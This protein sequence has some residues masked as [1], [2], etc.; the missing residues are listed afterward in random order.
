MISLEKPRLDFLVH[1]GI[2]GMHWGVRN[3]KEK[4]RYRLKLE[5][6]YTKKGLDS[7]EA[8][9][10]ASKRIKIEKILAVTAGIT[11]VAATAYVLHHNKEVKKAADE[12]VSKGTIFN[13]IAQSPDGNI[14]KKTFVS[15]LPE[16][17]R[18]Y[19]NNLTFANDFENKSMTYQV[20]LKGIHNIV[21]PSMKT[22][23]KLLLDVVKQNSKYVRENVIKSSYSAGLSDKA[24][25]KRHFNDL[26]RYFSDK[27][28]TDQFNSSYADVLKKNGYNAV[29][30]MNDFLGNWAKKP[31]ILLNAVEDVVQIGSKVL[32]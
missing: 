23:E 22:Q 9:K 11:L 1:F 7:V 5:E 12:I 8:E 20:S 2:L 13:R 10:A 31:V 24:F 29:I 6:K 25:V 27:S 28:L 16:D 19:E 32:R 3:D 4:S 26:L 14:S 17:V 30:D 21:M 18:V 15:F